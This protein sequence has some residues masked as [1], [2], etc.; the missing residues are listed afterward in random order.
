MCASAGDQSCL[1]EC[2]V[3]LGERPSAREIISE[4]GCALLTRNAKGS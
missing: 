4:R 1:G 2:S 3:E